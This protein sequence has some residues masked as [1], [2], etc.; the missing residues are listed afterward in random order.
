MIMYRS[1]FHKKAPLIGNGPLLRM[2]DYQR[3]PFA[4]LRGPAKMRIETGKMTK[5]PWDLPDIFAN[6]KAEFKEMYWLM[7]IWFLPGQTD[8]W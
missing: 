7:G 6:F 5:T 1:Y 3:V 2:F 4:F 8:D